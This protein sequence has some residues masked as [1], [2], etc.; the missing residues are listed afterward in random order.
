M[1][2][3]KMEWGIVIRISYSGR[4]HSLKPKEWKNKVCTA[5]SNLYLYSEPTLEL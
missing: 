5:T 2:K 4:F 3:V 1:E